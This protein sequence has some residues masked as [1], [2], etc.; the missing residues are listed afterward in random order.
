MEDGG[1]VGL[2]L[3]IGVFLFASLRNSTFDLLFYIV[4]CFFE[5][6]RG[7]DTEAFEVCFGNFDG[8]AIFEPPQLLQ[9]FCF[10]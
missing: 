10:L 2:W 4:F 9:G 5:V 3:I 6:L 7:I 8:K 1:E